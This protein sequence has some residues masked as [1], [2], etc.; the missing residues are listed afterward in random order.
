MRNFTWNRFPIKN[1]LI[2]SLLTLIVEST[3]Q[4]W[5]QNNFLSGTIQ[6]FSIPSQ[7]FSHKYKKAI[8]SS[9]TFGPPCIVHFNNTKT[10]GTLWKPPLQNQPKSVIGYVRQLAL[11]PKVVQAMQLELS[12]FNTSYYS[13]LA[14]LILHLQSAYPK[15]ANLILILYIVCRAQG[16]FKGVSW[17]TFAIDVIQIS[18]TRRAGFNWCKALG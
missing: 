9:S 3:Y 4:W 5:K 2:D 13:L 15:M 8:K 18:A 10:Y 17:E 11:S 14:T 12:K 16:C 6:Y 7:N 1:L